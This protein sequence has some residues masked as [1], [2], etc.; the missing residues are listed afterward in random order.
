[1]RAMPLPLLVAVGLTA[2]SWLGA[3]PITRASAQEGSVDLTDQEARSLFE[4]GR[5][6]FTA[7]R[8]DD[9]LGH[10]QRAYELS[11]RAVLL[12]NIGQSLDRLRR[13]EETL[14]T[15][16]RYL[17]AVPDAPNRPQVEARVEILRAALA[18]AEAAADTPEPA[19]T[20]EPDDLVG[21]SDPSRGEA[22]S[23]SRPFAWIS[24]GASAAFIGLAAG[25]WLLGD[26]EHDEL[27]DSCGARG[28]TDEEIDASNLHTFDVLTNLS[29]ALS[30]AAAVTSVVLFVVE[31]RQGG[32]AVAVSVSPQGL[33]LQGSF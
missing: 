6:A 13:D 23:R 19:E 29:L 24:A 14:D 12:F 17:E 10:F 22:P 9:A 27:A 18:E 4:A 20:D 11:G 5:S 25:F 30:I 2:L 21:A 28:C 26:G 31:G 8:F 7:G 33:R 3:G 16:E 32:D 1:M 15:F